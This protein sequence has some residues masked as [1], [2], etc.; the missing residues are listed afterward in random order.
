MPLENSMI[1]NFVGVLDS[2]TNNKKTFY[3]GVVEVED[4]ITYVRFDGSNVRTPVSVGTGVKEGQRVIAAME[5]HQAMI[6][7]NITD[8]PMPGSSNTT[9]YDNTYEFNYNED[10]KPVGV[11]FTAFLYQNGIDIK[12]K[13]TPGNNYFFWYI[14]KENEETGYPVEDLI[15]SGYQCYIDLSLYGYGAVVVGKFV[16]ND[17][18]DGANRILAYTKE[19][20]LYD[21]GAIRSDIQNA[22]QT[23]NTAITELSNSVGLIRVLELDLDA[24]REEIRLAVMAI[25]NES[26]IF[27]GEQFEDYISDDIPTFLNYPTFTDFFIWDNCSSDIYCSEFLIC[28]VNDYFSHINEVVLCTTYNRY[29]QFRENDGVYSWV[30]MT[31]SEIDMLSNR[32]AYISVKENGVLI[33]ASRLNQASELNVSYDGITAS[34]IF[35]C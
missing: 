5:N 31:M 26:Q 10:S 14:K 8:P 24:F 18:T 27:K 34:R 13:Y 15:G 16:D 22:E 2:T 35:C 12:A 33:K 19:T 32:Y 6:L 9:V 7:G 25:A 29:F 1:Q 4:D 23:A 28:G 21:T 11:T 17:N 3:R 30:E 20:V